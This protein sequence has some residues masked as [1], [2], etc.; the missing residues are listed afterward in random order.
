MDPPPSRP[1]R[2]PCSPGCP[3]DPTY[4]SGLSKSDIVLEDNSCIA[5]DEYVVGKIATSSLKTTTTDHA[6][7]PRL[8][9]AVAG[10]L[11]GR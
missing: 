7:R 9:A 2:A 1:S 5:Y 11:T 6:D 3:Y 8:L 4:T 10:E